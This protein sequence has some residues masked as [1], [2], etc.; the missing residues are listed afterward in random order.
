MKEVW[1][2]VWRES[3]GVKT[4]SL[5]WKV[6]GSVSNVNGTLRLSWEELFRVDELMAAGRNSDE[7]VLEV[8]DR[9]GRCRY[10]PDSL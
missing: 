8:R 1:R 2:D 4:L 5:K 10:G 9:F 3:G 6:S 7:A